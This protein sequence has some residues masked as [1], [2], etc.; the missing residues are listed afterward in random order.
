MASARKYLDIYR[1]IARESL[2]KMTFDL[3]RAVIGAL[4]RIMEFFGDST[5]SMI[6]S[7]H[8]VRGSNVLIVL[9]EKAYEPLLTQSTY[10]RE[11]FESLDAI[12]THMARIKEEA[13]Q[14]LAVRQRSLGTVMSATHTVASQTH[15]NSEQTLHMLQSIYG[16]LVHGTHQKTIRHFQSSI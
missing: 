11:L 2:E 14:L 9:I 5:F 15:E 13:D 6:R 8:Q 12:K 3:F 10:K 7:P 1:D 4:T 16:I